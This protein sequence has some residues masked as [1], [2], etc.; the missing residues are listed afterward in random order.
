[1]PSHASAWLLEVLFVGA[2]GL[3]QRAFPAVR[4]QAGVDGEDH[5]IACISA[6]D[7]DQPLGH[8]GPEERFRGVGVG[9][10]EVQ[11][12]VGGEIEFA[13]AQAAQ[14]DDHHLVGRDV[15][16]SS[17]GGALASASRSAIS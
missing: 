3:H 8:A 10:D 1:M 17:T 15:A 12:G 2:F 5:A 16:R 14:R 7:V 11:V 13:H 6:D 9:D 4:A